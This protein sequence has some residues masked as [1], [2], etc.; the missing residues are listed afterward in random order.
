[1]VAGTDESCSPKYLMGDRLEKAAI[2]VGDDDD[3]SM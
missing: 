3:V 2:G 1:M